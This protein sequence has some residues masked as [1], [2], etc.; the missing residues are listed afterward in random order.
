M[1]LRSGAASA[2][3]RRGRPSR[4]TIPDPRALVRRRFLNG[5]GRDRNPDSADTGAS[6]RSLLTGSAHA[7]AGDRAAPRNER[8]QPR[9]AD[10]VRATASDRW[11]RFSSSGE[12]L[13]G[14]REAA[15]ALRQ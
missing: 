11:C 5:R 4:K 7:D 1:S 13:T 15:I 12:G 2:A 6:R 10:A 9:P 3:I 14:P 8:N